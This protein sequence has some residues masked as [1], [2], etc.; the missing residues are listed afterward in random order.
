MCFIEI[1]K[2][3]S[4]IEFIIIFGVILI[5]FVLFMGII[6]GN[7]NDKIKENKEI[8]FQNIVLDV[9]DEINI[10]AGASEGYYREFDVPDNVYGEDYEI[11]IT[12]DYDLYLQSESYYVAFKTAEVNGTVKKGINKIKKE[13]GTVYLN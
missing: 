11:N 5:F 2:S 10:A 9:R 4:A 3:Q 13:N 6:K 12:E 7:Q 1:K 8:V